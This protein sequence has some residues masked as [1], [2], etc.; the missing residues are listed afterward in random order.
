ML[1]GIRGLEVMKSFHRRFSEVLIQTEPFGCWP[2]TL[3]QALATAGLNGNTILS[4]ASGVLT[5]G[6]QWLH[7]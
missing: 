5:V 4:M 7:G 1:D 3:D 2:P 6:F